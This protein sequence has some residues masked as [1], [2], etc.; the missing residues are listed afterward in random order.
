M[1]SGVKK[2]NKLYDLSVTNGSKLDLIRKIAKE[3]IVNLP[4]ETYGT[5]QDRVNILVG[6][7]NVNYTNRNDKSFL[8][9]CLTLLGAEDISILL[10]DSL[11]EKAKPIKL[12][13]KEYIDLP[14]HI[15]FSAARDVRMQ[16]NIAK[17]MS[18]ISRAKHK[19]KTTPFAIELVQRL[20]TEDG[21]Q[22]IFDIL[23]KE[24]FGIVY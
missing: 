21:R 1:G 5:L 3:N 2:T 8:I 23:E 15:I 22:E 17:N 24:G 9:A 18:G 11:G 6:N 4:P 20:K 16:L 19:K 12:P 10:H 13:A 7:I 14:K